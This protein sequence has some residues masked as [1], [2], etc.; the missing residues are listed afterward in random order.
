MLEVLLQHSPCLRAALAL[1]SPLEK[2]HGG[3]RVAMATAHATRSLC[4][5]VAAPPPPFPVLEILPQHSAD[6][7]RV[8][9]SDSVAMLSIARVTPNLQGLEQKQKGHHCYQPLPK[10]AQDHA[11]TWPG[12][13]PLQSMRNG[14]SRPCPAAF[15]ALFPH[16]GE[17][18]KD[19][20]AL[21]CTP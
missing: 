19:P 20:L 13:R 7:L 14:R 1:L 4:L 9:T 8:S 17:V 18:G 10:I 21:V 12:G 15:A 3:S 11:W 2:R 6:E 16:N 5:L